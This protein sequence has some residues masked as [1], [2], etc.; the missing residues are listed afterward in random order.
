MKKFLKALIA[1]LCCVCVTPLG[2]SLVGCTEDVGDDLVIDDDGEI[3]QKPGAK[4]SQVKFWINGDENEI[5]VFRKLVDEYNAENKG[6]VYVDMVQRPAESYDSTIA[7]SL[8]Q[9][10][11]PDVFYVGDSGYKQY[12]ELGYLYDITDLVERSTVYKVEDMWD[13]VV[14]RYKYNINTYE[15][16][17]VPGARYY[18]VPKDLGP[19]VIFYN[20]TYFTGA[21]IKV[22]SVAPEDLDD[23][24][25]GGVDD[26]GQTKAQL[27]LGAVTVKEKG[28]FEVNG[29]KYFNNQVPM[30]WEE[31]RVCAQVVQDYMRSTV[32]TNKEAYYGYFTEWWFNYGWS[33]GG[34]CIQKI[35]TDNPQYAGYYY[36]FTLMDDTKNYIV[37]DDVTDGVTVNG[38]HYNAGEIISYQ[39]KL[40]MSIYNGKTP[41]DGANMYTDR[42]LYK[43]TPEV[44]GLHSEGKLNEL[45]SQREAFAEFVRIGDIRSGKQ[46]VT[47]DGKQAYGICP[48][49]N[50]IGSDGAK[51]DEFINGRLAMLVDGRW[52]VTQFRR[53]DNNELVKKGVVWDV[54]PLPMYKEYDSE[55]NITVHGIEAGHSGSVGLCISKTSKLPN[56]AWTFIEFC[57]GEK[58]QTAQAEEGFAIPLQKDLAN[59]EVFLQTDKMPKNSKIFINATTY[60][61]AGDWWFLRD[62][63][64]INDWANV[65]NG[66]VRKGEMSFDD[67]YTNNNYKKTFALL[68]NYTKKR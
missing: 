6:K 62:N 51:T 49:P 35:P 13:N 2:I 17:D 43:I 65:L 60:E 33:V 20:E 21:G 1:A 37:A 61:Q 47:I 36:D 8:A 53:K 10:N 11:A 54:A 25:A 63:A 3:K 12:A 16:G 45:P 19:T 52:N 23:F 7:Q 24:N 32:S 46:L 56:A 5:A 26:R 34:N 29:Q 22:L 64:W 9:G 55:G 58:G 57:A 28:Y 44:Q 39:D 67:F 48:K 50:Q 14:T 31:T 41:A 27:G 38:K 42:S 40:D 66:P 15:S 59:S 18:G 68:G 4:E 30:S